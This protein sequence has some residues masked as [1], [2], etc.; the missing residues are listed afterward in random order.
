MVPL[1]PEN[2][3]LGDGVITLLQLTN[4]LRRSNEA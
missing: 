1:H 4:S 3:F 2:N